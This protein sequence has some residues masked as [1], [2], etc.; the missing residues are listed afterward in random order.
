M[1]AA[2]DVNEFHA[3][4]S[5]SFRLQ[6]A[7]ITIDGGVQVD[8]GKYSYL[9]KIIDSAC[10]KITIVKGAQMGF[11]IAGILKCLAR[12]SEGDIRGIGYWFPTAS[13]AQVFSKSRFTPLMEQNQHVWDPRKID[14]DSAELKRIGHV[15]IYLRGAGQ[16]GGSGGKSTSAVKSIPLDMNVL[17]EA[18]EMD[19]ERV[20][21]ISHRLDSSLNPQ[22]VALSTPTLPG[23]G[24]DYEYISS[25]QQVWMR[26]CNRCNEYNCLE[27]AY[28]DCIAEPVNKPAYY[29]CSK[30]RKEFVPGI[31]EWVARKPDVIDHQG[32]WISQL[33][34]PT[35]TAQDIVDAAVRA[36]ETGRRREFENQTLARAF[37][38]VD[39]EIT[40]QQLDQLLTTESKP[41]RHEGPCAMGVDPG[42][43]N[44][45]EVRVRL[46]ED[47]SMVIDRG[48]TDSYEELSRIAKKYNVESGIMD[49]GYDPS[50]VAKFCADH[51]GWYGGLY[52]GAKKGDPDWDH[53]QHMV[54][55]GRTRTLDAAHAAIIS[56]RVSYIQKDE[57]YTNQFVPQMCNLKRATVENDRTGEQSATWIVTGGQKNDHLRHADAYCHLALERCG[58]AHSVRR[59]QERNRSQSRPRQRRGVMTL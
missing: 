42:K 27:D 28:P 24:V 20:D 21:A 55:M 2:F 57:F 9:T 38:E 18:D 22:S 48:R 30:C 3:N 41:L 35:K 53:R 49:Q 6:Q 12:A 29:L 19:P 46:S 54:K 7:G 40:P 34:S 14:V 37:A 13:E 45:Y 50:A 16:R 8:F 36:Q 15:A 52:I 4:V 1:S 23:V 31:G 33:C 11:T 44:W 58:I 32:F 51:P 59:M 10:P 17:D 39:E 56:K 43:P 26:K 47:D 5:P 25:N